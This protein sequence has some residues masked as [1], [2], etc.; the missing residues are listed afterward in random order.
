MHELQVFSLC[1]LQLRSLPLVI[2]RELKQQHQRQLFR[3]SVSVLTSLPLFPSSLGAVF[4][5][6]C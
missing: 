4:A 6:R 5:I 1:W 3:N 2:P